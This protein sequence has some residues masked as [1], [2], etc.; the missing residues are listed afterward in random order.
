MRSAGKGPPEKSEPGSAK[1]P[2]GVVSEF[3]RRSFYQPNQRSDTVSRDQIA[4]VYRRAIDLVWQGLSPWLGPLGCR[5]IVNRAL[6]VSGR[7][8]VF[9][10]GM[11]VTET[12]LDADRLHRALDG[13]SPSQAAEGLEEL[14]LQIVQVVRSL[15]GEVLT[16]PL[17]AV[18]SDFARE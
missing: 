5:A 10:Q 4:L 11:R 2:E 6:D 7:K 1:S 3:V 16:E 15:T 8:W 14:L 9:L 13:V 17:L 12:G 18:L